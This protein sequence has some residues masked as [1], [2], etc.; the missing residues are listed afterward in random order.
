MENPH[1]MVIPYPAQGHVI[2]LMELS[3]CLLKHGFQITFVNMEFNHQNAMDILALK[4]VGDGIHLVSV[5]DGLGSAEERK[6][7]GKISQAIPQTM[8]GKVEELI[9]DINGSGRRINCVIADQSLGW[10]LEIAEKHGIKRAAFCPAAAALLVLGFSIPKLI[11]DGVIDQD[12]TPVKSEMIKLSPDMPPVNT[13]NFVWVC[14]GNI[15]AQ[16]NI[17]K[18]MIRNNESIKL[19]DWL[20]CNSSYELEPA[21]FAMA[22][23]IKPIGPLLAPQNSKPD[24]SDSSYL[25]WLNQQALQ[26][27]IYVAFGSFTIF[28][29][30]QFQELAL[31]LELTGRPFI[32]V[33]RSDITKGKNNAYPEGFQE[34]IAGRGQIVDWANQQKIL[35]HPSIACFISHCGWNSTIEGLSNGVP[36]LCWPYFADQFFNQSYI[37]EY[38]GV[39]LGLEREGRGVIRREEIRNKVEQVVGIDKYKATSMALKEIIMNS[40]RESGGSNKNMKDFVEWLNATSLALLVTNGIY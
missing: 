18:L 14:I 13:K 2:P 20:L 35:S 10:A 3:S 23:N 11:D 5:P 36:F 24:D 7:P 8:P 37:C 15:N 22:P 9:E 39:G 6:H 19:T 17:F 32:W 12:G 27:V 28:D 26:S 30:A 16:R 33:V 34:R 29:T 1:V 4:D 21:A 38:W 31:G 40:I 25:K